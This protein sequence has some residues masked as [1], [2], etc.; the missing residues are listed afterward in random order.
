MTV[1]CLN[2]IIFSN[3]VSTPNPNPNAFIFAQY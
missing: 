1:S 3:C 2:V